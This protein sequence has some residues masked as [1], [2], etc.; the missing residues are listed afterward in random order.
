MKPVFKVQELHEAI[1]AALENATTGV[2]RRRLE[3]LGLGGR[4][5]ASA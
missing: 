3:T 4:Q 2:R 1:V 5:A